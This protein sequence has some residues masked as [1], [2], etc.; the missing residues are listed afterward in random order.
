MR[1]TE[2]N[3]TSIITR[4]KDTNKYASF[5]SI[6]FLLKKLTYTFPG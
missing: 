5:D 6:N 2:M 3:E 1:E 4:Y